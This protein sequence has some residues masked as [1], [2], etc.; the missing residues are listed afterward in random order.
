M[1]GWEV[2]ALTAD[3]DDPRPLR[4][5]GAHAHGLDAVL[6]SSAV[7][8]YCLRA[9]AVPAELYGSDKRVRTMVLNVL[10]TRSADVRLWG[11]TQPE[12]LVSGVNLVCHE[13]SVAARAFKAHALAAAGLP[14]E[15]AL[16]PEVFRRLTSRIVVA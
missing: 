14:V 8:G 10:A 4:I 7:L 6:A 16:R 9:I 11:D 3:Q 15:E 1:R 12:S 2:N 13:P 5:L